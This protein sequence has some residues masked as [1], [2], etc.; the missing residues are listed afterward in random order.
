MNYI[1]QLQKE[2]ASLKAQILTMQT[3]LQNFRIHLDSPKFTTNPCENYI[4]TDEVK[5]YLNNIS[6][7][8][9]FFKKT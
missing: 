8:Y 2:N 5:R 4:N 9:Y 3:E 7:G 6:D 1:Q